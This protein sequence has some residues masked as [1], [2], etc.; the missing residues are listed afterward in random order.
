MKT[1]LSLLIIFSVLT[2]CRVQKY[3]DGYKEEMEYY[4]LH[5]IVK[6]NAKPCI[7]K[8][9]CNK[10][11]AMDDERYYQKNVFLIGSYKSDFT[12]Y[13]TLEQNS[14]YKIDTTQSFVV[15][16]LQYHCPTK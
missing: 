7:N 10:T 5:P 16:T 2:S 14:K 11:F 6:T 1:T 9:F 12:Y 8:I 4:K 3:D 13:L 15:D